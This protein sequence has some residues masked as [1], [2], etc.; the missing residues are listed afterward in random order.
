MG[1]SVSESQLQTVMKYVEIGQ[2]E[3]ATLV[4]GGHRLDSGA[5]ARGWFHEPTIF[6]D[7]DPRCASRRRRSSARWCR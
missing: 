1:P 5:Y 3:G 6:G 2:A 7:V 4:T